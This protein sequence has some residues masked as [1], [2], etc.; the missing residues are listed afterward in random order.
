M[1]PLARATLFLAALDGLMAVAVGA[2]GAHAVKATATPEQLEFLRTGSIYQMVH[3]AGAVALLWLVERDRLSVAAPLALAVGALLFA[4]ALYSLGLAG[5]SLGV[6]APTGG[7]LMMI[8]WAW[9]MVSA[10]RR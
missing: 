2:V 4:G 9:A 8:G 10:L 6:V 5:V 1:L 3:A 7:T